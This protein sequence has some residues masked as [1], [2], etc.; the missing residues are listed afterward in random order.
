MGVYEVERIVAKR[1]QGK[2]TPRVKIRR[3]QPSTYRKNSS[4]PSRTDL[5]IHFTS[6]IPS[7]CPRSLF[8]ASKRLCIFN[9]R[10]FL[11]SDTWTAKLIPFVKNFSEKLVTS[12]KVMSDKRQAA[13]IEQ[14]DLEPKLEIIRTKTSDTCT[15]VEFRQFDVSSS[16][17]NRLPVQRTK[18]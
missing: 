7:Y 5:S 15:L 10:S 2:T 6:I 3:N 11:F 16:S 8:I 13:T 4:L 18:C 17:L 14:R 12:I 1:F 9:L